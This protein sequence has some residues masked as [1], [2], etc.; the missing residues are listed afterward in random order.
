MEGGGGLTLTNMIDRKYGGG[1]AFASLPIWKSHT[2]R[3]LV[4]L[5]HLVYKKNASAQTA[6]H[7]YILDIFSSHKSLVVTVIVD[8]VSTTVY[9]NGYVPLPP[10][11]QS[12]DNSVVSLFS[13]LSLP[14]AVSVHIRPFR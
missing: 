10:K 12:S 14:C 1:R 3:C 8:R 9:D 6:L 13:S 2:F 7:V 4:F 5:F 11:C